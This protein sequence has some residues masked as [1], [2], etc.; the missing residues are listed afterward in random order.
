MS[1]SKD[2]FEQSLRNKSVV[3]LEDLIH[4]IEDHFGYQVQL[5]RKDEESSLSNEQKKKLTSIIF[6]DPDVFNQ[7]SQAEKD[8]QEGISTYSDSEEEFVQFLDEIK[9]DK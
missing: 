1:L 4:L 2:T 7:L 8:R 6:K 3:E 9:H 5:T